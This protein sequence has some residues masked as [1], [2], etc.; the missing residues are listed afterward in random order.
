M[1]EVISLHP[2]DSAGEQVQNRTVGCHLWLQAR[3]DAGALIP[4]NELQIQS[5]AVPQDVALANGSLR[6]ARKMDVQI[7]QIDQLRHELCQP[8]EVIDTLA[9]YLEMTSHDEN[10][11]AHLR[12]IQAMVVRANQ[13]LETAE[14]VR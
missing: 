3:V 8:L 11:C 7:S 9:H 12:K 6:V 2:I 10:L 14:A 4:M 1:N 13:I 5:H